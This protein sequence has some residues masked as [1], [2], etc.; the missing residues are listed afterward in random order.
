[1]P[2]SAW[3]SWE[4]TGCCVERL[5]CFGSGVEGRSEVDAFLALGESM[6]ILF[7]DSIMLESSGCDENC[8]ESYNG[9][10]RVVVLYKSTISSGRNDNG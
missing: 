7:I 3:N 4:R 6:S 10:L 5:R 9:W 1:M 8:E 2:D